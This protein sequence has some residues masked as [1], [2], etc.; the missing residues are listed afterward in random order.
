MGLGFENRSF[1]D[2]QRATIRLLLAGNLGGCTG[3]GKWELPHKDWGIFSPQMED[4]RVQQWKIFT[5]QENMGSIFT[6]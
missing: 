2:K 6:Y 3:L 4:S 5:T 1:L